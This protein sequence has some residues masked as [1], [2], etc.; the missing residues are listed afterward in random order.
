M[1][2]IFLY[3]YEKISRISEL[4]NKVQNSVFVCFHLCKEKEYLYMHRLSLK[5]YSGNRQIGGRRN[6]WQGIEEG[7]KL[8]FT[9]H[10]SFYDLKF[11][12]CYM[13]FRFTKMKFKKTEEYLA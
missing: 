3:S 5:G 6:Q 2:E 8:I 12:V 9:I 1:S 4:K 10:V 7:G 11:A 13:H